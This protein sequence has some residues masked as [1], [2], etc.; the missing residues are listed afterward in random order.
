[1]EARLLAGDL[2]PAGMDDAAGDLLLVQF[3]AGGLRALAGEMQQPG[4][5][6]MLAV[7][8]RRGDD[9]MRLALDRRQAG[10]MAGGLLRR[11]GVVEGAELDAP[12]VPGARRLMG[13]RRCLGLGDWRQV[14]CDVAEKA[15]LARWVCTVSLG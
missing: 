10:D 14:A 15:G 6:E 11:R 7:T 8:F 3:G 9:L 2:E 12:V 1:A 4:A 13:H 5:V